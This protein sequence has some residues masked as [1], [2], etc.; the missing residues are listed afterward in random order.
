M[1]L[2][3]FLTGD[4]NPENGNF[5]NQADFGLD[6]L[7]YGF[8]QNIIADEAPFMGTKSLFNE[9]AIFRFQGAAGDY[10]MLKDKRDWRFK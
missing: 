7:S 6:T 4:E 9:Y 1:A 3:A 10:N 8:S 2:D 5:K